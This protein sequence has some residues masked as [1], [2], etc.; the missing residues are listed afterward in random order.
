MG[1]IDLN[2]VLDPHRFIGRAP[3][4]VQQF[5][6]EA[7]EPIRAKYQSYLRQPIELRV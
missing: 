7:I 3:Q 1:G 4:Q 6:A 2:A 5:V